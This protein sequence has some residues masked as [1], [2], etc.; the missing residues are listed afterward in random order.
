MQPSVPFYCKHSL[1]TLFSIVA[2]EVIVDVEAILAIATMVSI[3]AVEVIV[4]VE[5]IVA[6]LTMFSIFTVEVRCSLLWR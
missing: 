5:V 6:I 1:F 3:V 2:V 4:D